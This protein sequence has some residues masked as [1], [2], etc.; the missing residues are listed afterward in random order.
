MTSQ[1]W[2]ESFGNRGMIQGNSQ[3]F[4]SRPIMWPSNPGA[5]EDDVQAL[6]ELRDPFPER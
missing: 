5:M 3:C 2:E 4:F 1:K 6:E